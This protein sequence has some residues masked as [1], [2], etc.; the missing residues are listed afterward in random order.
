MGSASRRRFL[1]VVGSAIAGAGASNWGMGRARADPLGLPIG[2]QLYTVQAEIG[3]DFEGTIRQVSAIGY[4]EVECGL[5]LGGRNAPELRSILASL[6]LGWKSAHCNGAE[7]QADLAKTIDQAHQAGL[8]YIICAF[9]V[10]PTGFQAVLKGMTLDD[11]K[12]NAEIFNKAGEQTKQAGIQFG[13]HNHNIEFR[14]LGDTT[15]YDVLLRESDPALVKFQLDCGWMASAGY[16]PVEYLTKY[17]G[18]YA[19]LH[20]KDLKPQAIP[21]TALKMVGTEIGSGIIDWR[22]LFRAA[23]TAGI[24]GYY[25]EQE[26]PFANS[27]LE[28]AKISYDYLHKLDV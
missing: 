25:V 24:S 22:R 17:P 1:G 26:A 13:F 10:V 15:G 28:S 23:K 3:K 7:I 6:G 2:L 19:M 16:D 14:K 12:A 20:V 5:T 8:R 27:P 9:P 18:R 21:N 4:R 11:W